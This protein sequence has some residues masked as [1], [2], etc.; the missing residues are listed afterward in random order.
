MGGSSAE[1]WIR[2][3]IAATEKR[4][5][6]IAGQLRT[7]FR[8]MRERQQNWLS[9]AAL[10]AEECFREPSLQTFQA[11]QKAAQRAGVWPA[12]RAAVM[13]HLETGARPQPSTP[14]WPLP[15]SELKA[16]T[17][18]LPIHPPLTDTLIDIAIAEKRPDEV[19]RW[20]DRR[21]PRSRGWDSGW[22][23]E[24]RVAEALVKTYP[25][26]ALAIWKRLAEAQIAL[27]N[28]K[29]YEQAAG[30]LRKVHRVLK[31]LGKEQDWSRYLAALRRANERKRRLVQI[32]DT[33][34]G[35]RIIEGL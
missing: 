2:K 6:G 31:Q 14:P 20:Y 33:L 8:E 5:P 23:A 4:W 7:A 26:R 1:Q 30:Y 25:E 11:L 3:G 17:E 29:A 19:L 22:F 18:R 9:V 15:E 35:R 21:K 27:T 24:D 12:V 34:A 16:T 28:P 10:H 13:H 32:L